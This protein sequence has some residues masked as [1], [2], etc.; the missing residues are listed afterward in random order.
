MFDI[1][2]INSVCSEI[3]N[4]LGLSEAARDYFSEVIPPEEMWNQMNE[5]VR[6][7]VH[8]LID[9]RMQ[10]ICELD[11]V[12]ESDVI[13]YIPEY[14]SETSERIEL[15]FC[16]EEEYFDKCEWAKNEFMERD[17]FRDIPYQFADTELRAEYMKD[18]YS[19]FSK[20]S[21]Y[22][23]ELT[24]K[25]ESPIQMGA[26]SPLENSITLND[27]LL[28][29]NNPETLMKT[30][31]HESRH[32][33]QQYAVDFPNRVSV[34]E[35]T[36]AVWKEN[37]DN[38]ILPEFDFEGYISQPIEVDANLFANRVFNGGHLNLS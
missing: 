23:P 37:M 13:K 16:D 2:G 8:L 9:S 21:G 25:P 4:K 38:Y 28:S 30:I 22:N 7:H 32:A 19:N 5:T 27:C 6:D 34:S 36:I 20:F 14:I 24:F 10:E 18:F 3:Q 12:C 29:M 11:H 31:F 33:F 17:R 15:P 1:E 35:N 26:Y